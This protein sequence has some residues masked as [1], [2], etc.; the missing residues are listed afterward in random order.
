M[1]RDKVS[2]LIF[3]IGALL[4]LNL[5]VVKNRKEI[6]QSLLSILPA[7]TIMLDKEG[8]MLKVNNEKLASMNIMLLE[9]FEGNKIAI[10]RTGDDIL[11]WEVFDLEII[12]KFETA[13]VTL[14][15]SNKLKAITILANLQGG[16]FV[17]RPL[18][19][20]GQYEY[21]HNFLSEIY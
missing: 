5:V 11:D 10:Q 3:V 17:T 6:T 16:S 13:R 18:L 14:K 20:D 8:E 4:V 2:I 12:S 7:E 21:I 15:L 9:I 1:R 19:E